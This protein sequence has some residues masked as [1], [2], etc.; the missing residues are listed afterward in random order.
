MKRSDQIINIFCSLHMVND[1]FRSKYRAY[2]S[3]LNIYKDLKYSFKDIVEFDNLLFKKHFNNLNINIE[4][5]ECVVGFNKYYVK[6]RINLFTVNFE[7]MH[8]VSRVVEIDDSIINNY[9]SEIK[10]KYLNKKIK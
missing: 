9:I 6:G 5:D 4:D 10:R 8:M 1:K 2:H 7:E 3:A